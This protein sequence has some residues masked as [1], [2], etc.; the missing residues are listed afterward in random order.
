[1]IDYPL[2]IDEASEDYDAFLSTVV[3]YHLDKKRKRKRRR[4]KRMQQRLI[5]Q[6]IDSDR[7]KGFPKSY[8]RSMIQFG[9]PMQRHLER[10]KD[11]QKIGIMNPML[12]LPRITTTRLTSKPNTRPMV[13]ADQKKKQPLEVSNKK[14]KGQSRVVANSSKPMITKSRTKI[15]ESSTPISDQSLAKENEIKGELTDA[16]PKQK[17]KMTTIL[18]VTVV[19]VLI[20]GAIVYSMKTKK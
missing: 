2:D 7:Y 4:K 10:I 11:R 5:A 1:M 16:Q 17:G 9:D 14:G 12:Q 18:G 8:K 19:G 3:L 15:E 13:T 20:T 6:L